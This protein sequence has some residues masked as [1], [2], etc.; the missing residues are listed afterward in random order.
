V[1]DEIWEE[2]A[3][4]YDERALAALVLSIATTM[5]SSSSRP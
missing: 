4:H 1:S 2:A 3:G 5:R